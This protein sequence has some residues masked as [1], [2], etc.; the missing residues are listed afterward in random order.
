MNTTQREIKLDDLLNDPF[1]Q[2]SNAGYGGV[3]TEDDTR[4]Q[5]DSKLHVRF[6]SQPSMNAA[7]SRDAG[8]P[9]HEQLDFVEIMVPGDKHSIVARRARELDKRRF[10]RQWAA[11]VA[12]KEDQ[13]AGTP[14]TA[15]PFMSPAKAEEYRFFNI[16]T[17]EQ[18][19][20]AAD[21]SSAAQA[22]MGFNGDKQKATAYLQMAAGN[23][24]ILKMQQAIEEKDNQINAMQE[25]MN[26]MNQR[27]MEL[28]T[29]S[30]KKAVTA[31]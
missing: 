11:Y 26:Q 18:L 9:I 30:N 15:L 8:R 13:Q 24:P 17:A 6:Y 16:V 1:K 20:A 28:S 2:R 27:L 22:I 31:E 10:S 3:R 21:G 7:K 29:K 4:F 19:A 5:N 14:L 25:Q 12:G 23:A